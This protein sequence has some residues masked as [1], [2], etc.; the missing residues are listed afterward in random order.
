MPAARALAHASHAIG[1]LGRTSSGKTPRAAAS[2]AAL[3]AAR[4]TRT[5]SIGYRNSAALDFLH[6]DVTWQHRPDVRLGLQRL[7]REARVARPEDRVGA[8]VHIDLLLERCLDVDRG[9][10]A[11]TTLAEGRRDALDGFV[12]GNVE[13]LREYVVHA[14]L[15]GR[16]V[17][18]LGVSIVPG[19]PGIA[20]PDLTTT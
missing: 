18:S 14:G 19:T 20:V 6:Y 5:I 7:V 4:T 13:S 8:E 16:V 2:A 9:E 11:E 17:A 15:L 12:E 10:N 1:G 3:A